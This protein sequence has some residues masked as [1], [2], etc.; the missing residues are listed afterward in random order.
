MHI[1]TRHIS[2]YLKLLNFD[3][4][5]AMLKLLYNIRDTAVIYNVSINFIPYRTFIP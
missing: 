5:T 1:A 4:N 3:I 2:I